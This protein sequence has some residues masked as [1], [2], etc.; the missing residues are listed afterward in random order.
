MFELHKIFGT[1][2]LW[3]WLGPFMTTMQYVMYFRF[4]V[5]RHVFT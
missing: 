1:C 5:C 3:P 2:Y 4:C